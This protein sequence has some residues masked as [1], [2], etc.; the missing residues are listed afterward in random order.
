MR[1]YGFRRWV[2]VRRAFGSTY[3]LSC[4]LKKNLDGG[5]RQ[6]KGS[7]RGMANAHRRFY[8]LFDRGCYKHP[9]TLVDKPVLCRPA[10]NV[11]S[12]CARA[13]TDA[14]RVGLPGPF[15]GK[16]ALVAFPCRIRGLISCP[17]KNLC[18]RAWEWADGGRPSRAPPALASFWERVKVTC[19]NGEALYRMVWN[20]ELT[21]SFAVR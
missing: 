10:N 1:P 6:H 19:Y 7:D 4:A 13:E 14:W 21:I 17:C 5:F 9:D 20:Q 3:G 16:V 15:S 2:L 8:N 18:C 12:R 11:F